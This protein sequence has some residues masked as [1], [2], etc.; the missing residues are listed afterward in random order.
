M[1]SLDLEPSE[2]LAAG[3]SPTALLSL[4][5]EVS[6]ATEAQAQAPQGSAAAAAAPQQQQLPPPTDHFRA[7]GQRLRSLLSGVGDGE[8]ELLNNMLEEQ[9]AWQKLGLCALAAAAISGGAALVCWLCGLDPLGGSSLS[10]ATARA[11]AVGG[12]AAAPLVAVKALLWSE[13]ARREL[14]FLEDVLKAQVGAER[15]CLCW[16]VLVQVAHSASLHLEGT[17][18]ITPHRALVGRRGQG[19]LL[20]PPAHR[21]AATAD[22]AAGRSAVACSRQRSLPAPMRAPTLQVESFRPMVS[23]LSPVQTAALLATGAD[24]GAAAGQ[25]VRLLPAAASCC[26]LLFCLLCTAAG[27]AAGH[28]QQALPSPRPF[29][30]PAAVAQPPP[31]PDCNPALPP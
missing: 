30:L 4:A 22:R 26:C 13:G 12:A 9:P 20:G 21:A 15:G 19:L 25:L 7:A 3:G 24:S 17:H 18:R 1:S 23:G 2:A 10:L 29:M 28:Q 16:W 8:E 11:A 6:E 14:P 27:R 31:P 5:S